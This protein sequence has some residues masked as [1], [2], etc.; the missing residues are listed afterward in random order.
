MT[1]SDRDILISINGRLERIELR[2]DRV[3]Q[4]LDRVEQRLTAVEQ[5][6]EALTVKQDILQTS[7]Y[8]GFAVMG[9]IFAFVG[10]FVPSITAMFTRLAELRSN[11]TSSSESETRQMMR[12]MLQEELSRIQVKQ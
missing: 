7:V 12:T 4:R 6:V 2:L 11:K 10:I 8:W 5:K 9:L 3:E 1:S